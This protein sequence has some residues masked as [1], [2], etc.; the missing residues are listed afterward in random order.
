MFVKDGRWDLA[1]LLCLVR[2]ARLHGHTSVS[3]PSGRDL[4]NGTRP[5]E[6]VTVNVTDLFDS[7]GRSR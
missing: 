7:G 5:P 2:W 1:I 3:T 6:R 4:W